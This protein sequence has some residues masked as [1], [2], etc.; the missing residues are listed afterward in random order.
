M[1]ERTIDQNDP[2]IDT[3]AA[4]QHSITATMGYLLG[5]CS[6]AELFGLQAYLSQLASQLTH[7]TALAPREEG[8]HQQLR[9]MARQQQMQ[10]M[11]DHMAK[12]QV[13]RQEG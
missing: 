4:L 8:I 2:D 5:R 3:M 10:A 12:K 7:P 6:L 13:Y 11:A 9:E 1:H